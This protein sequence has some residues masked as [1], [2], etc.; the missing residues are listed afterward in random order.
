MEAARISQLSERA[1][2][3]FERKGD[4]REKDISAAE[5]ALRNAQ[6]AFKGAAE[7]IGVK[8]EDDVQRLVDEVRY[9]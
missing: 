3:N 4:M 2:K 5:R 8:S 9:G 1:L 6:E 7:Q